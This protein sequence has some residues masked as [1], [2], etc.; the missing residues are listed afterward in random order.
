MSISYKK[1]GRSYVRTGS[2][3]QGVQRW[4][5]PTTE[6]AFKQANE[7]GMDVVYPKPNELQLDFDTQEQ[8]DFYESNKWILDEHFGI[9][10]ETVRISKSGLPHRHVYVELNAV[11]TVAS[12]I[13]LQAAM[14]S[15]RKR[16]LL[17]FVM[18]TRG[19]EPRPTLF[20]EPKIDVEKLDKV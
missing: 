2:T 15:D 8:Y 1:V 10:A 9:L 11:L 6:P 5:V 16:E 18:H 4:G 14:G 12:R 7:R 3:P 13:L 17:S 20:L 19:N